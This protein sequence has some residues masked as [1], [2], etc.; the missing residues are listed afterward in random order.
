MKRSEA[1]LRI[2]DKLVKQK[3]LFETYQKGEYPFQMLVDNLCGRIL[4]EVETF[5]LPPEEC[6][7]ETDLGNG[8]TFV[9]YFCEWESE[10]DTE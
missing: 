2:R 7:Q 4:T 9:D 1:V 6:K 8:Q 10:D 3:H 5:M